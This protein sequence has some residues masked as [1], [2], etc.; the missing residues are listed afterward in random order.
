M[1]ARRKAIS[2]FSRAPLL[3]ASRRLAKH[4]RGSPRSARS[5]V[6]DVLDFGILT[7]APP[8]SR[9]KEA[10]R[11][12]V[13]QREA[14]HDGI[15]IDCDYLRLSPSAASTISQYGS[16]ALAL[17]ARPLATT[18]PSRSRSTPRWPVCSPP[19]RPPIA[20]RS[21]PPSGTRSPS[22][23]AHPSL[24][25]AVQRPIQSAT[26]PG[27]VRASLCSRRWPS[28]RRIFSRT[29]RQRSGALSSIGRFSG[30]V[31]W[32]PRFSVR[33]K[34][35]HLREPAAPLPRDS[36][37][38]RG[39]HDAEEAQ[40]PWPSSAWDRAR[41]GTGRRRRGSARSRVRRGGRPDR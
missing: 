38:Q 22:R 23:A 24:L 9:V 17:G 18:P 27:P 41:L 1:D 28:R 33:P 35:A 10:P 29:R 3:S 14:P 11:R 15:L 25:D 6:R 32:P 16:H 30:V 36:R 2:K 20:P 39:R 19:Q 4:R 26:G 31:R 13:P 8:R 7:A 34:P 21:R 12:R 5:R 37:R 40:P